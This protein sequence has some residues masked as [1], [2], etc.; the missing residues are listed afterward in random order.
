MK[1][2]PIIGTFAWQQPTVD[3]TFYINEIGARQRVEYNRGLESDPE[4][5]QQAAPAETLPGCAPRGATG[6]RLD[7]EYFEWIDLLLAIDRYRSSSSLRPFVFVELGAGFG[8]WI[9]NAVCALR[10]LNPGAHYLA[11]AVEAEPAHC[12]WLQRHFADNAIPERR[13]R[14]FKAPIAGEEGMV[15]FHCGGNPATWYGQS[16]LTDQYMT[17]LRWNW[18]RQI[19]ANAFINVPLLGRLLPERRSVTELRAISLERALE[20]TDLVDIID[21]DIQGMEA[22]VIEASVKLLNAKVVRMHVET[23]SADVEKRIRARLGREGWI[24]EA[25]FAFR[26]TSETPYGKVWFGG[27]VQSWVNP[28]YSG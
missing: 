3:G 10:Q 16:V 24:K 4:T 28:R 22:D 21:M 9:V 20:G 27:G 7:E 25:D 15:P 11:I 13:Y 2:H 17:K 12:Q 23:H 18:L 19:H 6:P 26:T 14:L 8:R 1:A 5:V